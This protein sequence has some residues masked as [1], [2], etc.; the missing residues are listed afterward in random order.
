MSARRVRQ[1]ALLWGT[2]ALLALAPLVIRLTRSAHP[3]RPSANRYR[4]LLEVD[5]RGIPRSNSPAAVEIDF[6]AQL[7]SQGDPGH[8]DESTIEVM[9]LGTQDQPRPFDP[10]RGGIERF[11]LPWRLGRL[12]PLDRGTLSF[13]LPDETT[14]RYAVFFDTVE[15]GHGHPRRYPG[16]VGDGDLFCEDWGRR[17]IA[18]S[19][20]DTFADLDGDGDLD[21]IQ[22]GTA[23]MLHVFENVGGNRFR[24]GGELSSAGKLLVFPHD[25]ANR[26]WLAPALTDWDGDGDLDLFVSFLAGPFQNRVVLYQNVTQPGGLLTFAERG[27]LLTRSG[28]PV[29]G[30]ATFVDW[31]GDGRADLLAEADS[32]VA[33]HRGL[34]TPSDGA[35]PAFAD[36][37]YLDAN[38]VPIQFKNPRTDVA[39]IDGDGDI[40]LIAGT[41]EGRVYVF[42]N[43]GTRTQPSLA[44]GRMLVYHGYMDARAS[45]K[46]ADWDGDGLLDLVVGR[47]WQRSHW[48]DE[49]RGFGRL[50]KNVGT[51]GGPR[52]EA[53]DAYQGA[54]YVEGFLPADA[55]RQ[56]GVRAADWDSDARRDLILG[57]SDG[58]VWFFRGLTSGPFTLFDRPRRIQAGGHPLKVYGEEAEG[59]LAGYARPEVVDWN[60]DH[61]LD[62]LVADGR[63]WLT[64]FLNRGGPGS[65]ALDEGRRIGS[66]GRPIDGTA[67]G[68][69]LVTDWDQDGKKDVIFAM[70]GEGG[71]PRHDWPDRN[72]DSGADRGFLLYR[73]L[74]T[75]AEPVVA[76]P[77]WV[78]AGPNEGKEIDF[79]R[80]NLGAFVDWDGDG[81]RDFIACE[82]EMNCRLYLNTGSNQ[83]GAR[84]AFEGS[85]EGEMLVK[86]WVG[87]TIS[88]AE[89]VDWN[90]DGDV[91][92]LTGQGHGGSGIRF[93]EHDYL[94][95]RMQGTEPRVRLLAIDSQK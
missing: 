15:S 85:L 63:A 66:R 35:T 13:V 80:P 84:P 38:G 41:D 90:R 42:E 51:R 18:A 59:R 53:R 9:A 7:R 45:A 46:V 34:G 40:D 89:A 58:F 57:D 28:R 17:E 60:N 67:R 75:D 6:A 64:L 44:M 49:P 95:D 71:N 3:E 2:L 87:E 14:T 32:L 21:L 25:D 74:G 83:P 62:L 55:G 48:G 82:F 23:P 31:D 72:P 88:G 54:P 19:G 37:V 30:T 65:P 36:G 5:A 24:D 50:Y 69:V 56:N 81:K 43:V 70:V 47:Y 78:K 8:F 22:G 12:Y 92:I 73:N 33:F 79:N 86:P 27:P 52:F 61:R 29:V 77:K 94:R 68:S 16:L 93:F 91:D 20:Y 76:Y 11:L 10:R 26:S 4:I 39:D 1:Q